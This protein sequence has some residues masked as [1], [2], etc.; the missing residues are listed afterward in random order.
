MPYP[1]FHSCTLRPI[2]SGAKVRYKKRAQRI[3]GKWVDH[4]YAI[5]SPKKSFLASVR[6]PRVEGWAGTVAT[7][8]ARSWCRRNKGRFEPMVKPKKDALF[9][10]EQCNRL[11]E[12]AHQVADI[13]LHNLALKLMRI[14]GMEHIAVDELDT[15]TINQDNPNRNKVWEMLPDAMCLKENYILHVG[16]SVE[17]EKYNDI[18][19]LIDDVEIDGIIA[20]NIKAAVQGS[21]VDIIYD[22]YGPN[23]KYASLYD[24][25]AIKRDPITIEEPHG[26]IELGTFTKIGPLR[27]TGVYKFPIVAQRLIDGVKYQ[28][29]KNGLDLIVFNNQGN[30][31][32]NLSNFPFAADIM[33]MEDMNTCVIEG[34]FDGIVFWV[35]D[36]LLYNDSQTY[37]NSLNDRLSLIMSHE[38]PESIQ[39]LPYKVIQTP[40]KLSTLKNGK[41]ILRWIGEKLNLGAPFWFVYSAGDIR[42]GQV[43]PDQ[44][45]LQ[46]HNNGTSIFIF[47]DSQPLNLAN[48]EEYQPIVSALSNINDT[49][50]MVAKYNPKSNTLGIIDIKY[51]GNKQLDDDDSKLACY[52]EIAKNISGDMI[53]TNK[54]SGKIMKDDVN[55][56]SLEDTETKTESDKTTAMGDTRDWYIINGQKVEQ[57]EN[58]C[59]SYIYDNVNGENKCA[60][61][62]NAPNTSYYIG[63]LIDKTNGNFWEDNIEA[64]ACTL[65]PAV[66][67]DQLDTTNARVVQSVLGFQKNDMHEFFLIPDASDNQSIAGRYV[68]DLSREKWYLR[69]PS[70]QT[71]Y[72][73]QHT[74]DEIESKIKR[75]SNISFVSYNALACESLSKTRIGDK[76]L[77]LNWSEY[78]DEHDDWTWEW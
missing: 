3:N 71:P 60:L 68:I 53:V 28:I 19:I 20:S 44:N 12:V 35:Y 75:S 76:V 10:L 6:F 46:I 41:W 72:I 45:G 17:H 50:I 13:E 70:K 74:K 73:L 16:S 7:K 9:S 59:L 5:S 65:M 15:Q 55:A 54:V 25:W 62:L 11:H 36:I 38:Y 64:C 48:T 67:I 49:F 14:I 47:K 23:E 77:P 51:Y 8:Q 58:P 56:E 21:N 27:E 32:E 4:I 61:Y 66:E 57:D 31:V 1:N 69:K 18:D 26:V 24:L 39:P 2:P 33:E 29:H 34:V 30:V 52:N 37:L 43:I 78:I 40:D 63:L 22:E 42:P